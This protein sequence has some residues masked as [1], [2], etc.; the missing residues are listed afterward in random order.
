MPPCK[1]VGRW[2]KP[3]RTRRRPSGGPKRSPRLAHRPGDLLGGP[4]AF[5]QCPNVQGRDERGHPG[6]QV[7]ELD[8]GLRH[9][10]L[11]RGP[12]GGALALERHA[13]GL[14][15]ARQGGLR[16]GHRHQ[17]RRLR[18]GD[19]VAQAAERRAHQLHV[20]VDGPAPL[21]DGRHKFRHSGISGE[22]QPHCSTGSHCE[23]RRRKGA[24]DPELYKE[25][26]FRYHQAALVFS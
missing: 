3:G 18:P 16:L 26:G 12:V 11:G 24:P 1:W 21:I 20:R 22:L 4:S 25:P 10:A 7:L 19:L 17:Q 6:L 14:V 8:P 13:E 23:K 2:L 5:A 9:D 15:H